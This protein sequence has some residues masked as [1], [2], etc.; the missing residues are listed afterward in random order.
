MQPHIKLYTA[1]KKHALYPKDRQFTEFEAWL[2]LLISCHPTGNGQ[3]EEIAKKWK[4]PAGRYDDFRE[5]LV[6]MG[7]VSF[8][9]VEDKVQ[10]TIIKSDLWFSESEAEQA[11][12]KKAFCQEVIDLY[13]TT[14]T[15]QLHYTTERA[16]MIWS[17]KIAGT[18]KNQITIAS[19]KAVFDHQKKQWE[20]D[21]HMA[22][23]LELETLIRPANFMKYLDSARDAWRK[24]STVKPEE[25]I[26]NPTVIE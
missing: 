20:N 9:T 21:T 18:K 6:K 7:Q 23:H 22:K 5:A 14:F 2:D 13:N 3:W 15:R 8:T 26:F 4:W 24:Q 12:K 19:F 10:V 17:R 1:F 25:K 16:R 11:Q